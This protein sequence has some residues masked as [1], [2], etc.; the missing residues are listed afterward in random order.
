MRRLIALTV[1]AIPFMARQPLTAQETSA[2]PRNPGSIDSSRSQ[3][4]A[5]D[6]RFKARSDLVF[7][8]TRVRR[9]DGETIFGIK[10]EQFIV[11]DNGARQSI[12]VDED[13]D[14][15]GLS[16]IVVVQ[17]SRSAPSA[18]GK[19][20][21]LS[22]MIEEIVG[23]AP[24]EVSVMSYGQRPYVLSGFSGN[25]AVTRFALSRLKPCG[26]F[27]AA[28][29]DAVESA[30]Q[31]LQKRHNNYRRAVLLV[32]ETR[33]HGSSSNLRNV[34]VELGIA[35]TVIYSVA[36]SAAKNEIIDGFRSNSEKPAPPT[37]APPPLAPLAD[38]EIPSPLPEKEPIYADHAPLLPSLPPQF[39][40]A[41]NAL[42]KNT[43]SELAS[44]SGGEYLNFT[45]GRGFDEALQRISNQ[46]HNYYLL[47]FKPAPTSTLSIHS[48]R[49]RIPDYPDA[50]VQTRRS[51]WSGILESPG[52]TRGQ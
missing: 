19:L 31:M 47:S 13:P 50:V 34:V 43:A 16:M 24:R 42:R 17:C 2:D 52:D 41:I 49:V 48:I 29:V 3:T 12:Q 38:K 23:D 20:K 1:I 32:S 35:N 11:E 37:L 39:L 8:P 5:E 9:R 27:H 45:T 7:L 6:Y 33:D 25:P 22:A 46:I 18:F 28:T 14:T 51:Y 36:F 30:I 40:L 15:S 21:G 26:A 10:P 44:L 4:D